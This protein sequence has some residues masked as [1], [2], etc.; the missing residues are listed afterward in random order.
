M[1]CMDLELNNFDV[2]RKSL[3][4]VNKAWSEG[5]RVYMESVGES[6]EN[7]RIRIFTESYGKAVTVQSTDITRRW[8]IIYQFLKVG[9]LPEWMLEEALEKL[10]NRRK[11]KC[12]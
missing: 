7:L 9:Y 10:K 12:T 6:I 5:Q 11:K 2:N 3:E 4:K 8:F 1:A